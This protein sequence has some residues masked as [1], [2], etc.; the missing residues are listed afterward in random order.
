MIYAKII[1]IWLIS[2]SAILAFGCARADETSPEMA[3]NMLKL[4][5]YKYT[6]PE[7]FRAVSNED[8][9]AVRA[10][11]QA[12]MNP[13][14]KNEQGETALTYAIQNKDPKVIRVLL[15]R[16]DVNLKDEQ[17]NSP[18]HLAIKKDK[19]DIFDLLL[20]KNADVNTGGKSGKT[21]N[22]T[23]LY[24]AVLK[25]RKDL[26]QKLLEKGA[27]PNIADSDGAFPLSEA[28]VNAGSNPQIV[29]LLIDKGANINAQES[30]KATALIYAAA[31]KQISAQMRREIVKIL[32][33]RG[34]DKTIKDEKGRSALDWAKQ[35]GNEET[36]E[37]LK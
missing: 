36:A 13:N 19:E 22:Q 14:A 18:I 35:N 10:F 7:F 3:E 6:E 24:V 9:A 32:L 15:E 17:G 21:Q 28:V 29:K 30:N 34:A 12:G 33:D 25:G 16:A 31:N 11:M 5:G 8:G 4:R 20:E 2:I 27:D 23:A 37:L 1:L 26:V